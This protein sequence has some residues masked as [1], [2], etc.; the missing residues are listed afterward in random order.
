MSS[1]YDALVDAP[2]HNYCFGRNEA[3]ITSWLDY[4]LKGMT[5]VFKRVAEEVESRA[6]GRMDDSKVDLLRPLDH[7]ARRVLGLFSK[8]DFIQS[9][10][11]VNLLGISTRQARDLLTGWVDQGWLEITD[12][13][14]RGRNYGLSGIYQELQ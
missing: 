10:D 11:V 14:R 2:H 7:R 1:Y 3:N 13:S 4:F 5:I 9:S 12:P 6:K 8:Q